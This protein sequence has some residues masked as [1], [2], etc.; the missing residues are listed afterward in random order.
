MTPKQILDSFSETL[1][2]DERI[3]NSQER[4]LITALL[5]HARAASGQDAAT[6]SGVSAVIA[7]AIG[8]TIAQR[9]F[10]V[11]GG[12]IVEK[13]LEGTTPEDSYAVGNTFSGPRPPSPSGPRPPSQGLQSEVR[14]LLDS[15]SRE[16]LGVPSTPGQPQGPGVT[17][18]GTPFRE[19]P[20]TPSQPQGPGVAPATKPLR[21]SPVVPTPGQP[22]GPGASLRPL[23]EPVRTLTIRSSAAVAEKPEVLPA[24]CVILDE[25]LSPLE[26]DNL[27]HFTLASEACFRA[28]E[29]ISPTVE[30]GIVN[31]EHRRS[32]VLMD[33][34]EYQQLMLSRIKGVLPQVLRRLG[35]EDF[36]VSRIEAQITASNNGDYFHFHSD[37]GSDQVSSRYLTFVYFFHREPKQFEGGELRIHDAHFENGEYVSAGSYETI[38]PQQNQIVFFPCQLMHEITSVSCPSRQF[39]DSRFTLN[40]W[41]RK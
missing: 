11:L 25:F 29:V 4:S 35:M 27:T 6:Q 8:E 34:G 38:V 39:S 20:T 40:G 37:N 16:L 3:L 14:S 30:Q 26:L 22:Q 15:K 19:A 1:M 23:G 32:A 9:A 28:S 2:Q 31:Y 21:E 10:S 12:S 24:Q 18:P 36:D 17:P 5:R 13:I 41:L 7:S 33:V